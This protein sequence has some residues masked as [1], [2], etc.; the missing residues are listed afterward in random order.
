[1]P[2]KPRSV[3]RRTA[4]KTS[5]I[6][7]LRDD[8]AEVERLASALGKGGGT[9]LRELV[10]E[11]LRARRLRKAGRDEVTAPVRDAQRE[12]VRDE[13]SDLKTQMKDLLGLQDRI[14]GMLEDLQSALTPLMFELLFEAWT[15]GR[16]SR[17]ILFKYL[18]LPKLEE[19]DRRAGSDAELRADIVTKAH[20]VSQRKVA[21]FRETIITSPLA[22]RRYGA[23]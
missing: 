23:P 2:S 19:S 15:D 14:F 11:A 5:T 6:R 3:R 20:A 22:S 10:H 9:V 12:V 1:M 17:E 13:I 8:Y 4:T 18:L 21:E 7:L 16:I